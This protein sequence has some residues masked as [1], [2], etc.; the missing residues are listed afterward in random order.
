MS[1][2]GPYNRGPAWLLYHA[3]SLMVMNR[4]CAGSVDLIVADPPYHLSNGGSTCKSGKRVSVDK[5]M[6][7]RSAGTAENYKWNLAWLQAARRMLSEHGSIFVSGT[8]HNIYLVGH[9]MQELGFKLLN[10]ITWEKPAPP[11]NL[12]C[13]YFTHDH[14]TILWAARSASSK[15]TFNYK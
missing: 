5:G 2:T 4:L 9:A 14:E 1:K 8:R 7:D 6:W 15:Y 10:E 11:P 13:R 12:C 3:D